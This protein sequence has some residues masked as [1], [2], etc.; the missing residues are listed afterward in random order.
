MECAHQ[1]LVTSRIVQRD[2]G[3]TGK[4]KHGTWLV[5]SHLFFISSDGERSCNIFNSLTAG[6]ILIIHVVCSVCLLGTVSVLVSFAFIF[7]QCIGCDGSTPQ[8]ASLIYFF[9]FIVIFQFGW[10]A[11]QISHLSLIPELVSCQYAKVELTAFR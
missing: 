5:S 7:N 4:G 6:T 3:P 9:P 8:W 10:A 2:V 11:T 1:L